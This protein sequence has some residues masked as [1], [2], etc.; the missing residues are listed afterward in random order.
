MS[1]VHPNLSAGP[2]KSKQTWKATPL[3]KSGKRFK[4]V[5]CNLSSPELNCLK[6]KPTT[7]GLNLNSG[8]GS[9]KKP[10]SLNRYICSNESL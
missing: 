5:Y 2:Y 7:F 4:Y 8:L 10:M 6:Y 3:D 9:E 1:Q